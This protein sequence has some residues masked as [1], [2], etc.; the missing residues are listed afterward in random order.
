[1][2]KH[3]MWSFVKAL[4]NWN[5]NEMRFFFFIKGI[6]YRKWGNDIT[7]TVNFNLI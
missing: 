5:N 3:W 6:V 7:F 2:R 4:E 1:M